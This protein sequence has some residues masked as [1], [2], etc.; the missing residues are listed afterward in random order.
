MG[1]SEGSFGE[2]HGDGPSSDGA[3]VAPASEQA[4]ALMAAAV[5]GPLRPNQ[6]QQLL[7]ELEGRPT[8]AAGFGLEP[9]ALPPLVEHNP[10]IAVEVLLRLL[11]SKAAA[12]DYLAVMVGMDLSLH[13]LEVVNRL[14]TSA[15]LPQE[16][17]QDYIAGCI[18][19]CE[20]AQ[21]NFVQNRLVR[22]VCVF[23]QSL[24]RNNI[25]NLQDLFLEVQA[26]CISFSRIREAA[27]LFRLLKTL[28]AADDGDEDDLMEA[29]SCQD[30]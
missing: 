28:E 23:L 14:A 3:H 19:S 2:A 30:K 5:K 7:K 27:S 10:S 15:E 18:A 20:R 26:F 6:Q 11:K 17:V 29:Q 4:P 25:V 1:C 13:S 16:F 8:T 21:D 22:L 12:A 24:I 9:N